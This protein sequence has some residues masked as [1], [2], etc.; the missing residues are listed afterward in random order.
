M[1]TI[2]QQSS[3]NTQAEPPP[4]ARPWN[5]QIFTDNGSERTAYYDSIAPYGQPTHKPIAGSQSQDEATAPMQQKAIPPYAERFTP[6]R[7]SV[8]LLHHALV[9]MENK[10]QQTPEVIEVKREINARIHL[11]RKLADKQTQPTNNFEEEEA[12]AN[13]YADDDEEE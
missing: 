4:D 13:D 12:E 5:E 1:D 3:P 8:E 11:L 2:R 10:L 6:W 7:L 9:H